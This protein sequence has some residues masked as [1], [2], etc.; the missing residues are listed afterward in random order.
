VSITEEATTSFT[1]LEAIDGALVVRS[2]A[3]QYR[4]G[5]QSRDRGES[6]SVSKLRPESMLVAA[7]RQ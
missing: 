5:C 4:L 6:R 3:I 1:R 7:Q 2:E